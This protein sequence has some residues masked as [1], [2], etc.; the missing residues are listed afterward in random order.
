MTRLFVLLFATA[1]VWLT[2]CQSVGGVAV[3]VAKEPHANTSV[4][5][6]YSSD[7]NPTL[8]V[9]GDD[10]GRPSNKSAGIVYVLVLNPDGK[11]NAQEYQFFDGKAVQVAVYGTATQIS[12]HGSWVLENASVVLTSDLPDRVRNEALLKSDSGVWNIFLGDTKYIK[13]KSD[14]VAPL[15]PV[16]KWTIDFGHE[17]WKKDLC[18]YASPS[19]PIIQ[20]SRT[21]DDGRSPQA[22]QETLTEDFLPY[23]FEHFESALKRL[24]W[25]LTYLQLRAGVRIASQKVVFE[26]PDEALYEWSTEDSKTQIRGREQISHAAY[27]LSLVKHDP[28]LSEKYHLPDGVFYLTYSIAANQIDERSRALWIMRLQK[29]KLY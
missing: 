13:R 16:E 26:S 10:N 14:L 25:Q 12:D 20:Y 28:I 29:A 3:G 7:P 8:Q 11:Y 5:G 22:A 2:G 17:R 24:Q 9:F 18:Y 19:Q 27:Y 21:V 15:A 6:F 4:A 1:L 23:G